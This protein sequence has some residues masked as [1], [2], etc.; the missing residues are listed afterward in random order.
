MMPTQRVLKSA[1]Q[2][3]FNCAYDSCI[4]PGR[5]ISRAERRNDRGAYQHMRTSYQLMN[6]DLNSRPSDGNTT[7]S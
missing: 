2:L 3:H 7:G 6:V 4:S 5:G 1:I